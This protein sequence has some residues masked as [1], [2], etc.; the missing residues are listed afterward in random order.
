MTMRAHLLPFA[1]CLLA[2]FQEGGSRQIVPEE[3]VKAR[4]A[5]STKTAPKRSN[6]RP[7]TAKPTATGKTSAAKSSEFAQLGLT[8][9]R[10]RPSTAADSGARIIVQESDETV[11][12]T[13][14]RVEADSPLRVG[15]RIRIS[16]ESPSTG[17]LYVIDREQYADGTLSE[18]YLIFPT[19]RT[20]GGDNRVTA[21]RVI[22]IPGQEDRP[23]YF[24]LRQSRPDQTAEMLTVIV[25][26][27]PLEGLTFGPRPLVLAQDQ[28]AKWEKDWSA[29]AGRFELVGGA[30][31]TW[32]AAEQAAGADGMRLLTQEDPGPQTIYWVAAKPGQPLLVKVG[33]RYSKRPA[34]KRAQALR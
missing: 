11:E 4:P 19:T 1:F 3:F 13:P 32:T 9:W 34:A 8:I 7:A 2:F 26:A 29:P 24:R 25:T 10:L 14:E 28:V 12:W 30:G 31:K 17:Y 16:I 20:R 21:G 33:L 23:N 27:E 6:Y 22:E 5:K 15:E 18:P